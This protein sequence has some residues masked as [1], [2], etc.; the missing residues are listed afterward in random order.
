MIDEACEC[1]TIA[2]GPPDAIQFICN[3]PTFEVM[4]LRYGERR[5]IWVTFIICD[6]FPVLLE[7]YRSFRIKRYEI[8]LR[9]VIGART[10]RPGT[11]RVTTAIWRFVLLIVTPLYGS[12]RSETRLQDFISAPAHSGAWSVPWDLTPWSPAPVHRR[13]G[14]T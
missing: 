5:K 4:W 14:R 7:F 8:N 6:W 3:H 2:C 10:Y 1:D 11:Y 12:V 9:N 13:F